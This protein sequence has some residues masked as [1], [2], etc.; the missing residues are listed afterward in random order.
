M[1][2]LLL[3]GL[4]KPFGDGIVRGATDPGKG[5]ISPKAFKELVGHLEVLGD[6]SGLSLAALKYAGRPLLCGGARRSLS[7]QYGPPEIFNTDQGAQFTS[8]AFTGALEAARVMISMDRKGRWADNV[9]VERLWRS[10][11]L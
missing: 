4:I 6:P 5:E 7:A 9:F 10:V 2:L 8:Q 1:N 3:D 11:L